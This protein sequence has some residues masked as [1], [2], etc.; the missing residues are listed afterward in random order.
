M[1]T[2]L[3]LFLVVIASYYYYSLKMNDDP[4]IYKT[5]SN[6][7]VLQRHERTNKAYVRIN[8]KIVEYKVG[9]PY[10]IMGCHDIYVG[11]LWVMAGQSNMRGHGYLTDRFTHQSHQSSVL[12]NVHLFN[13]Q[14]AWQVASDPTH[15][16]ALS[17]RQVHHTLPDPTVKHPEL[18]E[19]RGASLGL[20]FAGHYQELEGHSVPVGLIASAH[21]GTSLNDWKRPDE[22][23]ADTANTTLYG[24]MVDRIRKVGQVAGIL[25][26]QGES[27]TTNKE[28]A[29]TYYARFQEWMKVLRQDAGQSM[30]FVFVQIGAHRVDVPE[31][32]A[33]WMEV[34]DA[35][36]KLFDHG[37][38]NTAGVASLDGGL[39]DRL[40]LSAVA[41]KKVGKRLA[42]AAHD[43]KQGLGSSA[44]PLPW[45]ARLEIAEIKNTPPSIVLEFKH[46]ESNKWKNNP[47]EEIFG[48]EVVFKEEEEKVTLLSAQVQEDRRT[49]R[50]Y[51]SD[52]IQTPI[53]VRY[54]MNQKAI[55]LIAVNGMTLPAF[56]IDITQ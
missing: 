45:R 44:T 47:G 49:I 20:A 51:L 24:A 53:S 32:V 23:N 18:L 5:I 16:L 35:Q 55:N 1:P 4:Y 14:E 39:D 19:C 22:I 46:M 25:W 13:S 15:R 10:T 34:Q 3:S 21:G 12:S 56:T 28:D 8:N 27:D 29:S 36:V 11:D 43:A 50:L 31:M 9:G 26:Y 41:L 33:G 7:Q 30:P 38:P 2:F 42:R 52:P 40:H 48:F 17:P 6:F 54:G 37:H